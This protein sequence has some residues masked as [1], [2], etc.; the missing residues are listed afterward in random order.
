MGRALSFQPYR[1]PEN[2]T[3]FA[4]TGGTQFARVTEDAAASLSALALAFPSEFNRA[5]RN[6]GY[7]VRGEIKRAMI[8]G[9][10]GGT[11]WPALSLM[12]VYRRLDLLKAA[13]VNA[14]T[15]KWEHGSRFALKSRVGGTVY[16]RRRNGQV[17]SRFSNGQS[18]PNAFARW[19]KGL[20]RGGLRGQ[21][22]GA[23][24]TNTIRYKHYPQQMRVRVGTLSPSTSRYLMAV[25][26]GLRGSRGIFQFS[27]SQPIT[28][29]MRRAFWAAGVPLR[30]DKTTLQ[31]PQRPLVEPVYRALEPQIPKLIEARVRF[32]LQKSTGQYRRA[33]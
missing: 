16:T 6:L 2:F 4:G 10:P 26:G 28:P 31:Q 1:G 19:G 33:A 29:D 27:G 20:R 7:V 32:L 21:P 25:Q 22:F 13:G 9:G 12:H 24:M 18:I 14:E 30:K 5:I 11:K 23:R 8:A 15:G 17:V 3:G